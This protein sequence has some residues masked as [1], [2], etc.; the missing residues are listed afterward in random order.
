MA[1]HYTS[2]IL[3]ATNSELPLCPKVRSVVLSCAEM[4]LLKAW[5]AR[6]SRHDGNRFQRASRSV[7]RKSLLQSSAYATVNYL[8][9]HFRA[10]PGSAREF[11]LCDPETVPR[12]NVQITVQPPTAIEQLCNRQIA[13]LLSHTLLK[14]SGSHDR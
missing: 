7:P 3:E 2:S 11:S 9:C 12:A 8:T 13:L 5:A 1:R 6:R 10:G 14:F 4:R